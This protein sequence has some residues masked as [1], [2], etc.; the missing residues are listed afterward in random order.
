MLKLCG[1]AASNYY[2]KAKF[3]LLEKGIPFEEVLVWGGTD[4]ALKG[5]SPLGKI[6][7]IEDGATIV[8]ESQAVV[9]FIEAAYPGH[10]LIPEDA[11]RASKV[12]ELIMFT[13]FYIEWEARRL[14]SEAFFGGKVSDDLK[15]HV[16]KRLE[17]AAEAFFQLTELT[18]F[19]AG[20]EFTLADCAIAVHFPVVSAATRAIYGRDLLGDPRI[21][22]YL[23]R[24]SQRPAMQRIL[25][26]RKANV[27]LIGERAKLSS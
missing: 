12:R 25:A 20:D 18:P 27:A 5:K 22:D 10:P 2:N 11:G 17:R 14:Y 23:G 7:Y 9:E 6:P 19:A 4:P 13:E 3:A 1:F 21:K 24:V 16:G 26:D 15:A 8:S